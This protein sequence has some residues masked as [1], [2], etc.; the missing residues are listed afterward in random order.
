[1]RTKTSRKIMPV[2]VPRV[3]VTEGGSEGA[4]EVV[5]GAVGE[6]VSCRWRRREWI[7]NLHSE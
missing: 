3:N 5:Q 7:F 4:D 1:M 2:V 6:G